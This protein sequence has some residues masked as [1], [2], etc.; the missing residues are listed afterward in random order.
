MNEEALLKNIT[1]FLAERNR[2]EELVVF[3]PGQFSNVSEL[4]SWFSENV[5]AVVGPHG[6]AMI[7]HRWCAL[8][9]VPIA[10]DR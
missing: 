5:I 8:A 3:N 7:N 10:A 9:R 6:G 1:A 2:G 4:F